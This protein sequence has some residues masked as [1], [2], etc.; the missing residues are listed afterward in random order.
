MIGSHIDHSLAASH[1]YS[2]VRIGLETELRKCRSERM[3]PVRDAPADAGS[4]LVRVQSSG[5]AKARII[6][7]SSHST[8]KRPENKDLVADDAVSCE[9]LSLLTGNLAGNFAILSPEV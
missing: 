5:C 7:R 1:R 3:P 9:L 8:R 4:S 2:L 6:A